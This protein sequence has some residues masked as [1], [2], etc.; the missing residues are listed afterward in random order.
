MY[1]WYTVYVHS[2]FTLFLPSFL[3]LCHFV[4]A[5]WLI[6]LSSSFA[7]HFHGLEADRTL[8]PEMSWWI[9]I[10]ISTV[11]WTWISQDLRMY[12]VVVVDCLVGN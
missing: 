7:G 5:A 1:K 9:Y 8:A 12:V 2:L 10:F 4:L 11:L 6:E 3:S